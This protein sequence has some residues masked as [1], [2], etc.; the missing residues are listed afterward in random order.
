MK[1]SRT[2]DSAASPTQQAPSPSRKPF[3][4]LLFE[5]CSVYG[6]L[7][8]NRTGTAFEGRCPRC[9]RAISI[10]TGQDGTDT[11]FFRG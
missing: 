8:P 10:P 5:C 3:V 7:Y 11:R 4:G 2:N 6:R 9:F 1:D